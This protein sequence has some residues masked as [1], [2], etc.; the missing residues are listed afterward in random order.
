MNYFPKYHD[1]GKGKTTWQRFEYGD[2]PTFRKS[3]YV[4]HIFFIARKAKTLPEF[5]IPM[6]GY[7]TEY[8]KD[9]VQAQT[10]ADG[11]AP[12]MSHYMLE[13][14]PAPIR[15]LFPLLVPVYRALPNWLR[16]PIVDTLI[17]LKNRRKL[18][19]RERIRC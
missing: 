9:F 1:F 18:A 17:Y 11:A 13:N 6:Q 19:S 7:Y 5:V 16:T 12:E 10:K 14:M 4:T 8:Y 15:K 2:R 3:N